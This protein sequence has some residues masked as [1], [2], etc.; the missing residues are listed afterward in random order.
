MKTELVCGKN[1]MVDAYTWMKTKLVSLF[2]SLIEA[3]IA[4]LLCIQSFSMSPSEKLI[5]ILARFSEMKLVN[6]QT[7]GLVGGMK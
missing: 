1:K 2:K 4:V 7:L 3:V 6:E 5:Q